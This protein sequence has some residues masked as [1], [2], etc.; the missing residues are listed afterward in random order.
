MRF[1]SI[2]LFVFV[3]FSANAQNKNLPNIKNQSIHLKVYKNI[4][5]EAEKI[6]E[7]LHLRYSKLTSYSFKYNATIDMPNTTKK[8]NFSGQYVVSGS[9]FYININKLEIKSDG[10]SIANIN[11]ET[12]EVQVNPL[13]KRNKIETPFDFIKNYKKLF[14]YR[15][16]EDVKQNVKMLELIPLEK[17]SNIF[18]I[19]LTVST[20]DK[21]VLGSKIYERSGV[22]VSYAISS[23]E[24]N[25]PVAPS[26]FTFL[27]KD[28]KGYEF[29]DMR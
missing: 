29:L 5:V 21:T 25:K 23:R 8:E 12:K 22:R 4:D 7:A 18:K 14:K 19:D 6:L 26:F 13:V 2:F 3:I 27:E 16:K 17:N 10:K 28:Y 15:V 9:K 1:I 11:H 24:E 20:K